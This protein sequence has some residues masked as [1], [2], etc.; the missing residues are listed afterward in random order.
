MHPGGCG[1]PDNGATS[2]YPRR[3]PVRVGYCSDSTGTVH[4]AGGR[5]IG[6]EGIKYEGVDKGGYTG[7]GSRLT[8]EGETGKFDKSGVPIGSPPGGADMDGN[9]ANS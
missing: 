5:P 3:N 8:M 2:I 7:D 6:D 4:G 1:D 9:G